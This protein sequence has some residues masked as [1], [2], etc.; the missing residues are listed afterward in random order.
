[1]KSDK[2]LLALQRQIY[3]ETR[4]AGLPVSQFMHWVV[5]RR[6]LEGAWRR[7]CAA[8]G[9]K[10]PGPD[11]LTTCDLTRRK[12]RW[13]TELTDLVCR[14]RYRPAVPRWVD[15]PKSG[16]DGTRRL[17]IL[18]V[19]D[20][21]VQAA[22]KQVLEPLVEPTFS[23]DSFGFRPGRSVPAA[24]DVAVNALN[25][26]RSSSPP[27]RF[28]VKLDVADCFGTINHQRLERRL[29]DFVADERALMLLGRMNRANAVRKA[30]L[31]RP[32][33]GVVQGG[34][35]SPLLCN[36]Y[37][38]ALDRQ[39]QT[40]AQ[41]SANGIRALRYADDLL[42]LARDRRL[43]NRALATA[44]RG[45]RGLRQRCRRDKTRLAPA[46]QGV[47]WLGVHFLPLEGV[48]TTSVRFGYEV[49]REKLPRMLERISEMT[50]PPNAR[51]NPAAFDLGQW[52]VSINEQLREWWHAYLFA[53]NA[54]HVF[55]EIDEHASQ[56]VRDLLRSVS[57]RSFRR[58][59]ADC[60]VNLRRGYRTWEI[61]G[62]RLLV[63]SSLAP[64]APFRL[65]HPPPWT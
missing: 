44:K 30:T 9:A 12:D 52:L 16:G 36:L 53:E 2:G 46:H 49:P 24:L 20:R 50:I 13:L 17:G 21:V 54:R 40:V 45:L 28:L 27:Y 62:Q 42:I 10:T 43:A 61:G 1:M 59:H 8:S 25:G 47:R 35:L 7:V 22:F 51:I 41:Q 18:N 11:G 19:A 14:G 65:L 32:T 58:L 64:R 3:R 29:A 5:D 37:L 56:R 23:P 31:W 57:G 55:R 26:K 38:D 39:L 15:V 48:S 34:S 60:R 33:A 63:L 4:Q 6:N